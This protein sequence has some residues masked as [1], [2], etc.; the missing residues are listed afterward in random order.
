MRSLARSVV[1]MSV[2]LAYPKWASDFWLSFENFC[3]SLEETAFCFGWVGRSFRPPPPPGGQGRPS[4]EASG[5]G[6]GRW[7]L[8]R[9]S[10]PSQACPTASALYRA[11]LSQAPLQG[12]GSAVPPVDAASQAV[13]VVASPDTSSAADRQRMTTVSQ[14]VLLGCGPCL[15]PHAVCVAPRPFSR[16]PGLWWR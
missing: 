10:A 16:C 3:V 11:M 1:S 5:G 15:Y 2:F 7:P 9:R 13:V 8:P 14:D 12:V 4:P 6:G